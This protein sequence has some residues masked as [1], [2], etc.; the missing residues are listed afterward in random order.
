M[1]RLTAL[2]VSLT[3]AAFALITLGCETRTKQYTFS[4]SNTTQL[5]IMKDAEQMEKTSGVEK[6]ITQVSAQGEG[7]LQVILDEDNAHYGVRRAI[8]DLGYKIVT[9]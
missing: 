8:E 1:R 4:K 9:P 6:V 2:N 7:T 3:L 5:Q